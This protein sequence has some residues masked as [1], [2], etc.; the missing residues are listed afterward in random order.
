M[1]YIVG[2][3][4]RAVFGFGFFGSEWEGGIFGVLLAG[5]L[6]CFVEGLWGLEVRV[7]GREWE[8]PDR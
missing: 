6:F 7:W 1:G 5:V 3:R 8:E 2:S 4:T